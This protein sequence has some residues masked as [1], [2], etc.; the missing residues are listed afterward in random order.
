[1]IT[2]CFDKL[3]GLGG[4]PMKIVFGEQWIFLEVCGEC[5]S[6]FLFE[7]FLTGKTV[8]TCKGDREVVLV[9]W[10][11]ELSHENVVYVDACDGFVF[12]TVNFV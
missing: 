3:S 5:F 4:T 7:E 12:K 9:E 2:K 6:H 11:G 1:M 10:Q 8:T